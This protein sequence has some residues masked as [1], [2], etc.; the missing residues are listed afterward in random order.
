MSKTNNY[1]NVVPMLY[2]SKENAYKYLINKAEV[3]LLVVPTGIEPVFG[4]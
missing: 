4:V 1:V 3:F 2:P